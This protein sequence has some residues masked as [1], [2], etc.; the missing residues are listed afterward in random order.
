MLTSFNRVVRAGIY[1][2]PLLPSTVIQAN[3]KL[4]P[5]KRCCLNILRHLP[6]RGVTCYVTLC[7]G[8][9]ALWRLSYEIHFKQTSIVIDSSLFTQ[10]TVRLHIVKFYKLIE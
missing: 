9:V 8:M 10:R 7:Y 6:Q 3:C 4:R 5:I 1:F 2:M